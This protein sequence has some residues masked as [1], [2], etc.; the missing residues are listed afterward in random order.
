MSETWQYLRFRISVIVIY[1]I[2]VIC[3]LEFPVT[4]ICLMINFQIIKVKN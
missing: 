4:I 3:Y 1:L 2:F